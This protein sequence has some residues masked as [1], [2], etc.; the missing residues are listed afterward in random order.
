M[1]RNP[2]MIFTVAIL[3]AFAGA[4]FAAGEGA[5]GGAAQEPGALIQEGA[6]EGIGSD[7][8]HR[9][10]EL[11][12]KK[13]TSHT[14]EELGN[15]KD[16]V[17]GADGGAEF[18]ILE[19]EGQ[20]VP[21]PWEAANLRMEEGVLV[22]DVTWQQLEDAPGFT[23]DN[24]PDFAQEGERF[25]GYYG[26]ETERGTEGMRTLPKEGTEGM[27]TLPEGGSEKMPHGDRMM[28]SPGQ[29]RVR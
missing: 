11:M 14:G 29:E 25:H 7:S 28:E 12:D 3:F 13:V 16:F 24:W 17:L 9:V 4:S 10:S 22:A 21:V 20:L 27:R 5:V 2:I 18:V 8:H 19:H 1:R 23:E 6:V 26:Q 15:I